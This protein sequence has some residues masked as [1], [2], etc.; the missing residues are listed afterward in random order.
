MAVGLIFTKRLSRSIAKSAMK[1]ARFFSQLVCLAIITLVS[2]LALQEIW[3]TSNNDNLA[4]NRVDVAPA[5]DYQN[6]R[7]S[8]REKRLCRRRWICYRY[9]PPSATTVS[10]LHQDRC[11]RFLSLESQRAELDTP[12]RTVSTRA[13]QLLRWRSASTRSQ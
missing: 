9:L 12:N 4:A 13:E 8:R 10:R 3:V 7:F 5:H 1:R 6:K 2:A 11:W